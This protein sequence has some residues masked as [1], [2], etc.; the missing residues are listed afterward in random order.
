MK[1]LKTLLAGALFTALSAQAADVSISTARGEVSLPQNPA[2]VAVY[3]LSALDTLTALGV[4]VG[5]TIE[6]QYVPYLQ[7]AAKGMTHVGGIKTPDIEALH[8]YQPDLVIVGG[9]TASKY[10]EVKK[11]FP[12]TIDMSLDG[13]KLEAEAITRLE[14]YGKLFNKTA[15]ADAIKSQLDQLF[16]EVKT[17]A[18]DKGDGLIVLVNGNKVSAYGPKS[19]LGWIHRSLGIAEADKNIEDAS[20]GQPISFEYIQK[21]NPDW[22]FVLDR[23]AA[24]GKEGES[25][26]SVLDNPLVGQ[27]TAWKKGQVVYFSGA[28]YLA[29]GGVRQMEI[30]AGA[31]KAAFEKE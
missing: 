10:D 17:L 2:K 25:A 13:S 11:F 6:K 27:T 12:N 4:K 26:A 28:A 19:R 8:A 29:P 31:I 23:G 16:D 22:L 30:D 3:D 1:Y 5:A 21:T 24:I 15:E 20:H 7:E 18:K 14:S 9:R